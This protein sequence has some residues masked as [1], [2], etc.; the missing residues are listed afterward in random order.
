MPSYCKNTRK[1]AVCREH[2][3]KKDLIRLYK[4]EDGQIAVDY[5]KKHGGRGVYIHADCVDTALKKRS[6]NAAFKTGVDQNVYEK[7]K[8]FS[9]Q[10]KNETELTK[11]NGE[12][13][14]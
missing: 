12:I 4:T 9:E 2:S 5:D 7:L 6:L 11:L 13:V 14:R 8:K 1:C 3:E 10:I